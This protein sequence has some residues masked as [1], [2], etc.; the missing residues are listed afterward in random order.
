MTNTMTPK[1]QFS[2]KY[3]YTVKE[4]IGCLKTTLALIKDMIEDLK[5]IVEGLEE[6]WQK[7]SKSHS[8]RK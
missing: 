2:P 1:P 8:G 7:S 4:E 5:N 6:R 3:K